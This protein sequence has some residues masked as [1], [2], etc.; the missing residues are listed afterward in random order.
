MQFVERRTASLLQS[1]LSYKMARLDP[2]QLGTKANSF[3]VVPIRC[4]S[5]CIGCT[6]NPFVQI[7]TAS[8]QKAVTKSRLDC[9]YMEVWWSHLAKKN[10][11]WKLDIEFKLT[12][13]SR[14]KRVDTSHDTFKTIFLYKNCCILIQISNCRRATS[15]YQDQWGP[16]LLMHICVS[17]PQFNRIGQV[18]HTTMKH[19]TLK[20]IAINIIRVTYHC[21]QVSATEDTMNYNS[22]NLSS[23]SRRSN[24]SSELPWYRHDMKTLSAL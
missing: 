16:S 24:S 13:W 4:Y 10:S 7:R 1:L 21:V 9:I 17:W 14:D 3:Y 8:L 19:V 18:T 23:C 5:L 2:Q 6:S 20:A 22:D 15:S 12:Y 11:A